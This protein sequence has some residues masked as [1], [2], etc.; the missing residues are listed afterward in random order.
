MGS[1]ECEGKKK[2]GDKE[3]KEFEDQWQARQQKV[4][5]KL[6]VRPGGPGLRTPHYVLSM[7]TLSMTGLH[8]LA[9]GQCCNFSNIYKRLISLPFF[10][11]C[12]A[13]KTQLHAY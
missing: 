13:Y 1:I 4:Q 9:L 2:Q 10:A 3:D 11:K 5:K 8:C 12:V 7:T 6:G